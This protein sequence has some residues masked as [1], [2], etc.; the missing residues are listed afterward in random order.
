MAAAGLVGG[1]GPETTVDYYRRIMA[2]WRA[3]DP[4]T[5]THLVIDS[6]DVQENLPARRIRSARPRDASIYLSI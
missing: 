2:A 3:H 6:I 4:T 5:A 1:L